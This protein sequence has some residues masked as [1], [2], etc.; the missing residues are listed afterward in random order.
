MFKC[1]LTL[2]RTEPPMLYPRED[3]GY[4]WCFLIERDCPFKG[5]SS[6]QLSKEDNSSFL[7]GCFNASIILKCVPWKS[8]IA[9]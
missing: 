7:G 1:G 9:A 4:N 6:R 8:I 5:M 3:S 2:A